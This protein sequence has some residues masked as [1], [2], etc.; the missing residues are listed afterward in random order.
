MRLLAICAGNQPDPGE[1]PSQRPVM[2]GFDVFFDLRMNKRLGKQSWG[3]W[4]ETLPHPLW[5]HFNVL[6]RYSSDPSTTHCV[7]FTT[8]TLPVPND[9][10]WALEDHDTVNEIFL[11]FGLW[12]VGT[13][14]FKPA[15]NAFRMSLPPVPLQVKHVLKQHLSKFD[16]FVNT[17]FI[18]EVVKC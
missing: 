13:N 2:R 17:D 18:N 16:I 7:H 9:E 5:R 15:V 6:D 12:L 8:M 3:W 10:L 4:F 1:F 14:G 11:H